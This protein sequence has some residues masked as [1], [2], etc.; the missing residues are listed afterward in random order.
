MTLNEQLMEEYL[1]GASSIK[2]KV[3]STDHYAAIRKSV[4]KAIINKNSGIS[5]NPNKWIYFDKELKE[6][7]N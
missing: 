1:Q 7:E 2:G 6:R 4:N 5:E 3:F